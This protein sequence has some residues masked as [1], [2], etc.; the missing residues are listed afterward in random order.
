MAA[1]RAEIGIV[2]SQVN[3][4][5]RATP[6]L[7][8][9]TRWAEPTPIIA[10]EITC[11]VETGKWI[12]VAPKMI[13]ADAKSAAA[14]FTGRIF[15]ILPPTVLIILYPPIDVPNSHCNGTGRFVPNLE[16]NRLF[17]IQLQLMPL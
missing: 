7:T 3:T 15:I 12:N 9:F 1:I 14:P 5:L 13:E 17:V 16:Q 8:P 6:H 4:I 2:I 11:V 10:E